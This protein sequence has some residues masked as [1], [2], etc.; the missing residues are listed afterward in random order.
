MAWSR[1]AS[2]WVAILLLAQSLPWKEW[3]S[4][5][6]CG[7]GLPGLCSIVGSFSVHR[8]S[9]GVGNDLR[10]AVARLSASD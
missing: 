4:L 5:S 2:G 6:G 1:D 7:V 3:I 9:L 8:L 10:D